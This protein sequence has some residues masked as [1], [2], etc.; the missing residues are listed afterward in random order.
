MSLDPKA[1]EWSFLSK[2]SYLNLS[3]INLQMAEGHDLGLETSPDFFFPYPLLCVKESYNCTENHERQA[4]G[5]H[6]QGK[7]S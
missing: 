7:G 6:L 2:S 1:K 5:Q 3:Q 4:P